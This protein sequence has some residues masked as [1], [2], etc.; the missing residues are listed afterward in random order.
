MNREAAVH[1]DRA[2]GADTQAGEIIQIPSKGKPVFQ[3]LG[4]RD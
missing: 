2:T 3:F 4:K 1:P